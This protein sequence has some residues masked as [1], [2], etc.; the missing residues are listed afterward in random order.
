MD[1]LISRFAGNVSTSAHSCCCFRTVFLSLVTLHE[2]DSAISSPSLEAFLVSSKTKVLLWFFFF[3][4]L[5]LLFYST[6]LSFFKKLLLLEDIYFTIWGWFL[7]YISMN[8]P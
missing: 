7:P 1:P 2:S 3:F 6:H 4:F 5:F 8:Q